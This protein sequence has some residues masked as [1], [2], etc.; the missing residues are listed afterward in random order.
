MLLARLGV[1]DIQYFIATSCVE[2]S[3]PSSP[4]TTCNNYIS[5][6]PGRR[7]WGGRGV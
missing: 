3:S 7:R 6:D 1:P 2:I 5:K 4:I